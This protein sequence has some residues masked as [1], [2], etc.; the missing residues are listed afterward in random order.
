LLYVGSIFPNA[1]L[2]SLIE[3]TQAI[4]ELNDE[5]F[6]AQLRIATSTAN[7]ARFG[8]RLTRH[9]STILDTANTDDEAFFRNLADADALLLPVN[10]DPA[11]VDFIRYS[12]PT[13]VPAY[14]NSG[15]PVLAYGSSETAQ[16][17]YAAGS[18]WGLTVSERSPERLKAAMKR[19]VTDMSLRQSL[20]DAARAAAIAHDARSIRAAFRDILRQSAR[21]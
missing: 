8:S 3:C 1:Q 7:G 12:M 13:K 21:G 16:M 18:G 5:G 4:A 6:P 2:D 20:S 11:S 14:L 17:R 9:R 10:F 19:I 15:T